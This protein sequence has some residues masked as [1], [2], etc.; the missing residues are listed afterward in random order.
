MAR[1][2]ILN[3]SPET[4]VLPA[5]YGSYP[6][7]MGHGRVVSD[8]SSLVVT[9][10]GGFEAM[11]GKWAVSAISTDTAL[12]DFSLSENGL[13]MLAQFVSEG[14][15]PPPATWAD[16][17]G[18]PSFATVATSGSYTDLTDKPVLADVATSGSYADLS[19]KP[20]IPAASNATPADVAA[21]AAAGVQAGFARADHQH[22]HGSLAG[23]SLHSNATTLSA[24]FMSAA[25]KAALDSLTTTTQTLSTA[26]S[27]QVISLVGETGD[28]NDLI[29]KPAL[30]PVATSG[31]YADLT[32]KPT[33][34][35]VATTGYYTDL[36][37]K[38]PLFSGSYA[39]LTNKPAFA[40]VA[41]TGSYNDLNSKPDMSVYL[42]TVPDNSVTTAKVASSAITTAKV[43][44]SA[45][46]DAKI[47]GVAASKVTGLANVATSGSFTDLSNKP[48]KTYDI[49]SFAS[50]AQALGTTLAQVIAPRAL[51]LTGLS[52]TGGA[53]VKVQVD[54]VDVASYPKA[55]SVGQVIAFVVSVA[56][57]NAT[58]T[59][60]AVEA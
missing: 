28:Y 20:T 22:A 58:F 11:D 6:V 17:T 3:I 12:G 49:A 46:T 13:A 18:K 50:G 55:V 36:L 27:N 56:G 42:T 37:A 34:A 14:I 25:D 57:T 38:P 33:L 7:N 26:F 53:T 44:D 9:G 19:S 54:G 32:G 30:K 23:G 39:D 59:L 10:L 35:A 21:T 51:S 16:L 47:A 40:S 52:Q 43:A 5:L 29:N 2:L 1:T 4:Q 31:A 48:A 41:T 45:I 8:E 15:T 24:G 60:S